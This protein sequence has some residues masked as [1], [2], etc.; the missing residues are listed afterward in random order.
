MKIHS[1]KWLMAGVLIL[2]SLAGC[3]GGGGGSTPAPVGKTT[4][5]GTASAGIIYPG[6]VYVY[7]VDASG[8]KGALLA[9]PVATNIDGTYSAALG[10][11][12]GAILVEA[13]GNY[14]DEATGHSVTITTSKPL[15]AMVDNVNETTNNNRVV[16][17]T[18]LTEMAWRKASSN[19]STDTT[20]AAMVSSNKLVDDLFKISDI[21]GI[22][23][24][25]ADS[26]TMAN[27]SQESQ[28]YTLALSALSQMAASASGTSDIEKLDTTLTSMATEIKTAETTGSI[29]TA[30]S[31]D[32]AT[33]LGTVS[34]SN[35]FQSAATQLSSMGT[36]SQSLTLAT[37]GT[38]PVGTK[39][40]AL[41]GTIAIPSTAS[42][43]ADSSGK[44]LSD[45]LL[46]S[47]VATGS[48]E[49]PFAN[50][51]ALQSQVTFS[52][53]LN[54]TG[55]GIGIGDFATLFYDVAAGA[56]VS[57]ADFSVQISS[58]K[59]LNGADITGITVIIK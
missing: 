44:T 35:E 54:A 51:L 31:S 11:Y 32:F 39:I 53:V 18:P 37:S 40:F 16:S 24:V 7:A 22:E 57:P 48:G 14:T 43:R 25:R 45:V 10:T 59:D 12:S 33:A 6:E 23:P 41:E 26:A 49:D 21:I 55:A 50:Y 38:L 3:G 19:G 58:V 20:P 5:T 1:F 28:A 46:L 47:G 27:S 9:G 29:S 8:K 52:I 17:I 15:H 30:T 56:T 4:I 2:A 34:L 42:L 13:S 36:K